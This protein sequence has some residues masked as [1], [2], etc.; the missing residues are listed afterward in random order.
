MGKLRFTRCEAMKIRALRELRRQFPDS[1]YVFAT[2]RCGPFTSDAVNR[3][4]KRIGER[5]VFGFLVYISRLTLTDDPRVFQALGI[6]A[7]LFA[8][9]LHRDRALPTASIATVHS[10]AV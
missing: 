1:G 2:E 9:S 8:H 6:Q 4:I 10:S 7:N 5:A 3:L